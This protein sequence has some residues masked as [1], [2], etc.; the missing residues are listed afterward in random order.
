MLAKIV[1]IL[2]LSCNAV[3][4]FL[5]DVGLH[6]SPHSFEFVYGVMESRRVRE[7]CLRSQEGCLKIVYGVK[8]SRRVRLRRIKTPQL[9]N[10][11]DEMI[12]G[13]AILDYS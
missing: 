12:Q 13:K 9:L 6:T 1:F 4:P 3:V 5:S 7:N 11:V 8:E 2:F 10:S